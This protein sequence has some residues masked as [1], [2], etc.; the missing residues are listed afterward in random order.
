MRGRARLLLGIDREIPGLAGCDDWVAYNVVFD[1][2]YRLV[3]SHLELH[4]DEVLL[5]HAGHH[6]CLM[7]KFPGLDFGTHVF[8]YKNGRLN[9]GCE[10]LFNAIAE[11][12]ERNRTLVQVN[13]V[14]R[15]IRRKR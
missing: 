2:T 3:P 10:G 6:S 13:E 8:G 1:P 4:A 12:F 14:V 5:R 11:A 15:A 9:V 7:L